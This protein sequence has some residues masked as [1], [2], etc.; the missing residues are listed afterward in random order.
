MKA[1][2]APEGREL[3]LERELQSAGAIVN[4]RFERLFLCESGP[5]HSVWAQVIWQNVVRQKITSIGDAAKTLK[6][7]QR[8]WANY[9]IAHFRRAQL[10]QEALP[11]YSQKP[12]LFGTTLPTSPMGGWSLIHENE[13]IYSCETNSLVPNGEMH[14][15]EDKE[16]PPSR[17]YLKLWEFFTRQGIAPKADEVCM[18]LGA[19]PGGWTWVLA[20]LCKKVISVDKAPLEP[21]IAE[22]SNVEVREESAFGIDPR[23]ASVEAVDWLFSD[24]ICYPA[25]LYQLVERWIATDKARNFVCTI[26]FQAETD[27]ESLKKFLAIPGANAV[28]LHANKHEVTWYLLR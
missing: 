9:P 6:A 14:F 27:E 4:E 5:E 22:L 2:I 8:N 23:S 24:I 28:H 3:D 25:R 15:L 10:I 19:C 11:Y 20:P 21:K 7:L 16:N 26:K 1:Y 13:I 12:I 17:A 18:D